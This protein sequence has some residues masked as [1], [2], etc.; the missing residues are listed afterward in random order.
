[1]IYKVIT[2][3]IANK[4]KLVVGSIVS[5]EQ[6]GF[7]PGRSLAQEIMCGYGRSNLS[8]RCTIKVD[9][10][11]AYDMINWH[12]LRNV[13]VELGFPLMFVERIMECVTTPKFSILVNG[14]L[15]GHFPGKRGLRQGD[16]MSPLLFTLCMEYF[17]RSL[18]VLKK[19][20]GFKYHPGCRKLNITH[21]LFADDLLIFSRGD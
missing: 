18:K 14:E 5:E 10:M 12:F 19:D 17:S 7:V 9:L 4:L 2:T 15:H 13:L 1:L 6:G 11:K 21:I 3:L 8:P 20:G 16:P